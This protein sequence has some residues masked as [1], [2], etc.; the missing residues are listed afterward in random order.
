MRMPNGRLISLLGASALV[1]G[2]PPN[3]YVTQ[4][5]LDDLVSAEVGPSIDDKFA[6]TFEVEPQDVPTQILCKVFLS[7][8]AE[9][10]VNI[11]GPSVQ[12]DTP[13][14]LALRQNLN[15]V[16]KAAGSYEFRISPAADRQHAKAL[17]VCFKPPQPQTT[18]PKQA[19]CEKLLQNRQFN[20]S[21]LAN[22]KP[23]EKPKPDERPK[24]E[25]PKIAEE[26][27]KIA[28]QPA[29]EP[30]G[31]SRN[32]TAVR[33]EPPTEV[34]LGCSQPLPAKAQGSLHVREGKRWLSGSFK[35]VEAESCDISIS[36]ISNA[37]SVLVR[38]RSVKIQVP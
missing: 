17:F 38:G 37:S 16:V 33:G 4:I 7:E 21:G 1:T 25:R 2:C 14:R 31:E 6:R 12:C 27:P 36:G 9:I 5:A 3:S 29:P 13:V 23:S 15:C 24:I 26:R 8:S 35:V 19:D 10:N 34:T 32:I 11:S 30:T 18:A 20:V 22:P 28:E